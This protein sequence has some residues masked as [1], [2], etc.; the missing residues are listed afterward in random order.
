MVKP[1]SYMELL[2]PGGPIARAHPGYEH[3]ASQIRMAEAVAEAFASPHHLMVEAGTGTGKT[4]AYLLPAILCGRRVVIS[5]AT[6]NLQDQIFYKD[7]PFLEKALGRR[8]SA[9]YLKGRANYLC[10]MRLNT[11]DDSPHLFH[12]RETERWLA[13]LHTWSEETPT[14]DRA[15]LAELPEDWPPWRELDARREICLGQKCGWFNPCFVTRARQSALEADLVVVNHHLYFADLAL[16]RGD[17]GAV[18]PEHSLVVFDEAHEMED[19]ASQF[20][21]VEVSNYRVEELARDAEKALTQAQLF[22]HTFRR[23]L[24]RLLERSRS[25]FGSFQEDEGRVALP[26]SWQAERPLAAHA[27]REL[28]Q[29]L[30]LLSSHLLQ[31]DQVPGAEP[32]APLRRRTEEIRQELEFVAETRGR[33]FVYWYERRGRGTFLAACPIDL[34]PLLKEKLFDRKTSVVLTSATLTASG[35]F[36]FLERRL[37]LGDCTKLA[38]DSHFDLARQSILYL[39]RSLPDPRSAAY[40][41]RAAAEIHQI[42]QISEGRAFV[43]STSFQQMQLLHE[44]LRRQLPYPVLLQGEMPHHALLERFRTTPHAVLFATFSFWHGVDVPGDALSCV[45]I[46]KLPFSVPSDPVVA[47]RLEQIRQ[48]GGN[49]FYDLQVPE[50]I[51]QLKQGLG[52][53]IRSRQDRGILAILDPRVH[54]KGYGQAFLGSLPPYQRTHR[55]EDLREFFGA[56]ASQPGDF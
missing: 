50:A 41:Y 40:A 27:Y 52:R 21:G 42:L 54:R 14:G 17:F 20:F 45:I 16:Q 8:I 36:D 18:L 46:D 2:G 5:T 11:W 4:L 34:A 31:L 49:P 1:I 39:P 37:G 22:T 32:L 3:R 26:G 12:H 48:G 15:E 9:C 33:D 13:R 51:I 44:L 6:R 30:R 25:F 56:R 28:D 38:L 19:V 55:M 29:A 24:D 35:T 23:A 47:A 10:L 43:L 7:L 53:L